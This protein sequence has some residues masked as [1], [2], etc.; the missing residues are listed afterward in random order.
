[1]LAYMNS[2]CL[3][4]FSVTQHYSDLGQCRAIFSWAL[5]FAYYTENNR[6]PILVVLNDEQSI[7]VVNFAGH[8]NPFPFSHLTATFFTVIGTI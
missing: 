6:Q 1:M 7:I 5:G 2:S 8:G 4:R 3:S